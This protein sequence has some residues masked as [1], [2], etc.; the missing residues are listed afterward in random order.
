VNLFLT[1]PTDLQ[2]ELL[3]QFLMIRPLL[4]RGL[5]F[6]RGMIVLTLLLNLPESHILLVIH[7]DRDRLVLL[8]DNLRL[9]AYP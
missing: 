1:A 8:L 4:V 3:F 2:T 5:G 9:R 6:C 7:D